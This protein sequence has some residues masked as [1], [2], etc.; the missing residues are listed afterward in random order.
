MKKII[1]TFLT[2]TTLSCTMAPKYKT[3]ESK[4]PFGEAQVGNSKI[5][6]QNFFK[7]KDLQ[8]LI[9]AALKNNKDLQVAHLNVES[10]RAIHGI[11]RSELLPGL[12][13][14]ASV[15]RQG[16]SG[17]F[18][19]FTPQKIF[20]A[21]VALTT[22]ELDFFGRVQSLKKAAVENFFASVEA[23]NLMEITLIAEVS[24][25]YAQ[26][27]L[28]REILEIKK[29]NFASL[30]EKNILM[31]DRFRQG[32]DSKIE[33]LDSNVEFERA[34]MDIATYEKL[35][36]QDINALKL[37]VGDL[38]IEKI[39]HPKN[40]GE[41][42][43][44]EESL[45]FLPSKDLL[46]RPDIK[47]AEH[48]LRSA[49]ANIGAARAAFFP[50]ISLTGTYGYQS[51]EATNLFNSKHWT[52]TPQISV[53][54]FSGGR[55]T[56]NLDNITVLKE[57]EVIQYRQAIEKAFSETLDKLATRKALV[58]QLKSNNKIL[59][60]NR[61]LDKIAENKQK[62]GLISKLERVDQHLAFLAAKEESANLQKE[63]LTNLI[64]LYKTLGGGSAIDEEGEI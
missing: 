46:S 12:S 4:L 10:A 5:A 11:T 52:F 45:S 56:S 49:N 55:A 29:E 40:L 53:P 32:I 2:L 24:N 14:N 23:K 31:K 57:I 42:K 34:K 37:L 35:V 16:T 36:E 25:S 60:A 63:Y 59:N 21:N 38:N 61:R 18:A 22:Y 26:L 8:E 27:A 9:E 43:I 64:E 50:I 20:R 33:A 51:L 62:L 58:A 1:L 28:D 13:A 15:T 47:Q 30:K 17:P 6:W 44:A 54:L 48:N 41:V 3:P 7:S 19:S 39:S